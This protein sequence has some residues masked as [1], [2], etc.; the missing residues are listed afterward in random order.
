MNIQYLKHQQ[1]DF[2]KWDKA[3]DQSI[4]ALVYA[5]SWYLNIV[6]SNWDALV[7]GDYQIVMPLIHK[8]KYTFKYLYKPFFSQFLGVFYK[9][10]EDSK[11]VPDFINEAS[12]HFQLIHIQLNVSNSNFK[13]NYITNRQTQVLFLDKPYDELRKNYN[14]SN[15]KNVNKA[16]REDISIE[17]ST[18]PEVFIEM[19]KEMYADRKVQGVKDD[20]YK[21]L[22][23]IA[24]YSAENN[25]GEIHYAYL[26]NKICASAYFLEWGNRIVLQ[27]AINEEG[28]ES[29]VIFKVLDSFIKSRA[30]SNKILDFAGSNIEG[31]AYRNLG[32]G[33]ENQYY[34][35]VYL[36]NLPFF[37]KWLKRN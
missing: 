8:R 18:D 17:K 14:R 9:K 30:A 26:N 10:D 6:N 1:I 31:V 23:E 20:D 12:R 25:M 34:Y 33:A 4:N 19:T 11:Y 32:F 28:K 22:Y 5:N 15:R 3:I 24:K 13:A 35:A 27:T 37:I 36:N 21:E 2:E 16:N 29:R 7:L